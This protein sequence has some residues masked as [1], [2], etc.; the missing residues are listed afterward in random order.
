MIQR[1]QSVFLALAMLL[2]SL[3]FS[4]V[5]CDFHLP[6]GEI[7][8]MKMSGF[9]GAYQYLN[10]HVVNVSRFPLLLILTS[11]LFI[12]LATTLFSYK[13]RGRQI[14]LCTV[15]FFINILL[16][17]ILFLGPDILS[18]NLSRSLDLGIDK[19]AARRMVHYQ[20]G[21]FFPFASL[22]LINL[23][24]RFIKKDENL[25]KSADRLR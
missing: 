16:L 12:L 18:V 14:K 24:S 21:S 13:N 9:T 10:N 8:V 19:Q 6:N 11:V 20:W 1:V 4:C 3:L 5:L 23:A 25:V 7:A 2:T 15:T 17:G 22:V